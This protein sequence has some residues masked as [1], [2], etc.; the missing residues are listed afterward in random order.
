MTDLAHPDLDSLDGDA[1]R[2]GDAEYDAARRVYN[3]M[4]DRRPAVIVRCASED[5][6][7]AALAHAQAQGLEVCV[8]SGGHSAPGF[9]SADGA[10]VIDVRRLKDVDVDTAAGT[11]RTG[12]GVTWGELDAATQEHGFAVTGGRVS[13]TGMSGLALGSGSGWLE[14]AMGLTPDNLLSA[15]VVTAD[16]RVVIAS[17]AEHA[18]LFWALRGGG[19]N[20]GVVT[21]FTF[22]LL[23]LG[24]I[25][26]GGMLI[27]PF[28]RAAEV[29]RAYAEVMRDAPDAL[30]G[31]LALLCAPPAPFVPPE[32]VGKPVVAVI[33]LW[34]GA[35]ADADAGLAPLGALGEPVIDLVQDMPYVAVQQLLDEGNPYGVMR[36]YQTSG[37]LSD[38]DE[39]SIELLVAAA[40]APPSVETVLVLQPMGGAYGRVPE[41]AT[42]L[43]QRDAAWAYQLLTQWTDPADDAANRAWTKELHAGLQRHAEA[44]AFPNFVS[45][46]TPGVLISA[47]PPATLARLQEAKRAWDP[48]N[49][50][51]H[52]HRLLD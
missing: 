11:V 10:L 8:R 35:P 43:G 9:S 16:G 25:V 51:C 30:C 34:A 52:N 42:A 32:A 28:P 23:R 50:F 44:P 31:G 49:V 5:D 40:A 19:G 36:E 45:D 15:R 41:G 6:V 27:F 29:M 46:T 12:A 39:D 24:P 7:V 4:H 3:T 18:D 2:P 37:F 38:L 26:R 17:E 48:G 20:F 21:E 13:S 1:L 33:V 14:R 47:Y 22:R